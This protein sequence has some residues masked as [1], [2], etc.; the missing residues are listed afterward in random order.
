MPESENRITLNDGTVVQNARC[1]PREDRLFI[2]CDGMEIK[3]GFDTF[4]ENTAS[5]TV[6]SFGDTVTYT[7]FTVLYSVTA[8]YGNC[9]ISL[10]KGEPR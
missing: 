4:Y 10:K 6:F 3:E 1:V 2:Y 8:E 9:N 7:G 5:V